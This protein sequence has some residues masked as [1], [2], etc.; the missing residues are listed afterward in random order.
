MIKNEI[1][2]VIAGEDLSVDEM[3][4]CMLAIMSGEVSEIHIASFL[5]ALKAKG[6]S[7]AEITGGAR[8]MREKAEKVDLEDYYTIDTCGTGGDQSGTYNI[9]TTVS[10]IAAAAGVTIV[11]HGNR[12][13]SSQCGAADVLEA[14]GVKV[15]LTPAQVEATV[16][17]IG[18][19]FFFAPTFH[20]AM[21]YVG[22]TRKALGFRTIF[23]IL[24]PL[25]NPAHA[26]A[27]V[28]GVFDESLTEVMANVLLELGV[29]KALVVHG[30]CG[31]DEIST[32]G[33][34]KITEL[35]DGK[36][37]T[38][39]IQPEDFGFNRA[40]LQDIQG[41]TKEENAAIIRE[42]LN[43]KEGPK[44]DILLLNAGAALYVAEKAESIQAGISLAKEMI[45]KGKA[46]KKLEEFIEKTNTFS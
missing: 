10:M 36:I 8:A 17:E 39:Y 45:R 31:L 44:M 4:R 26:K 38:Y 22:K 33:E 28:L 19:G 23:N 42:L 11:K 20:K 18:I 2:K 12:S 15:D 7:V 9:S 1:E 24:G 13:V 27:Q 40:T 41:G 21:K 3:T 6:E 37:E 16:K 29:K 14:L 46:I 34:T 43:G 35:K 25:T 5:T 30:A 32:V